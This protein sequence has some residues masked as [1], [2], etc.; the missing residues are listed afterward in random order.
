MA[1]DLRVAPLFENSGELAKFF[2]QLFGVTIIQLA[3]G[4]LAWQ[5]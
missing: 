2:V 3:T 1:R 4:E 5:K